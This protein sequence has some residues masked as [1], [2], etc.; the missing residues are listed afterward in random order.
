MKKIDELCIK[1][2]RFL[3]VDAVTRAKSGHPGMPLGAAPMAYT[4]WS[5]HLRFN[6]ANPNWFNRDRFILSAGHG[7]ALLYSLL[8]LFGYDLPLEEIKRFRQWGSKTPGHP[9]YGD[10]PGVEATTG[11]LGQGI[12][13]AV[14]MAIAEKFLAKTFNRNNLN[15]IDHNT[16]VIASDGDLMEGV[17]SEVCSL[18]GTLKLNKLIVLYDKNNIS[19]EGDTGAVFT[20]NV[21][22]RYKAY[23]WNVIHIENGEDIDKIDEA[24]DKSKEQKEKPSL[25]IIRTHIGYGSPK[26]DTGEVHGSPLSKEEVIETKQNLG[27]PTEPD[28]LI[29]DEA[30][31]HFGKSCGKGEKLEKRWSETIEKY[32]K[33][34]PEEAGKL[35]TFIQGKLPPDWDSALPEFK[36]EDGPIATRK[37]SGKALNALARKLSN[38]IGGSADLAPSNNTNLE[39]YGDFSSESP[40]SRNLHFGVREHAMGTIVN[41]MALHGGVIPFGATFLIFSD[42]MRPSLRLAS[43]MKCNSK[44]IFT[45]DSIG[46]GEDG[47]TH[48]PVEHLMSLRAMPVMI[49]LRPADANETVAAWKIAI[50]TKGPVS[51][52]LTRQNLPVLDS[53][54]YNIKEGVK[55]GAYILEDPKEGNPEIILIGT[56]SEVHLALE[57]AISLNKEGKKVRVVS[58]PSFEL[59]DKQASKYKNSILIP[60]IPKLAI[61]AG[62]TLGW[63]DYVGENGD[64]LGLNRFGASAP[65]ETVFKELEFTAAEVIKKAKKLLKK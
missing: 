62:A 60:G 46:L 33:K 26:Q 22:Q 32:K 56:G 8:H 15:I 24:I 43:L 17:S 37:A 16:Y 36:V 20:E 55:R 11:P 35:E 9:E 25:I 64:I 59:F 5:R 19:I 47:P 65:G 18:A 2:I 61:E 21:E 34:Y 58:M 6:P 27:W 51:L 12:G 4:L 13:M 1:T 3:A 63:R 52:A 44:F 30:F 10:I 28:F 54:K 31:D 14:G 7:S 48:Q 42:Y 50:E 38:L 57:A 49:V 45:H 39:G 53:K 40:A 29:P 23:D 41:G